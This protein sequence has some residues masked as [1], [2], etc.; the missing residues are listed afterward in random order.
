MTAGPAPPDV[1]FP[2]ALPLL[3]SD[4][5]IGL[6]GQGAAK[7]IDGSAPWTRGPA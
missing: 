4:A 6:L 3:I 1:A 5:S 2:R 7:S